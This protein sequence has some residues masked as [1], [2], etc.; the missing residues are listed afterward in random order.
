MRSDGADTWDGA[1]QAIECF[2]ACS[3]ARPFAAH[4][5]TQIVF[6]GCVFC[7]RLTPALL[8]GV[9]H[10]NDLDSAEVAAECLAPTRPE[11][12]RRKVPEAWIHTAFHVLGACASWSVYE[13]EADVAN[14]RPHNGLGTWSVDP[15]PL[16]SRHY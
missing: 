2:D 9:R 3:S 7:M 13:T 15:A 14:W 8:E 6:I 16:V 11:C 10:S 1:S 5:Q 4:T 12:V